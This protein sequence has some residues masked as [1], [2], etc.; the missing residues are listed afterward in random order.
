MQV[1]FILMGLAFAALLVDVVIRRP[2]VAAAIIMSDLVVRNA[3]VPLPSIPIGSVSIYDHDLVFALIGVAALARLLRK[4]SFTWAQRLLLLV[5]ALAGFSLLRGLMSFGVETAVNES[6]NWIFLLL[7]ALYFTTVVSGEV[8]DRV[9]KVIVWGAAALAA[10]AVMRWTVLALGG[11]TAFLGVRAGSGVRVLHAEMTLIIL[12]GFLILAVAW[13]RLSPRMRWLPAVLLAAVI[14]MQHR[15]VWVSL[16][17]GLAVLVYRDR[18]LARR[19]VVLLPAILAAAAIVVI[20]VFGR[21]VDEVAT[22]ATSTDTFEWRLLGWQELVLEEG[23]DG[24]TEVLFGKG[25]GSG[26]EREV[27][28]LVR[29][30]SPHSIYVESALRLGVFGTLALLAVILGPMIVLWRQPWVRPRQDR[31]GAP[32]LSNATLIVLLASNAAFGV[33]YFP[34]PT[35]G[36][37]LGVAASLVSHRISADSS[38]ARLASVQPSGRAA[39]EVFAHSGR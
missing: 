15:T 8:L 11:P 31:Y 13:R 30:E 28:N 23:P 1:L 12:Q 4:R 9:F 39:G 38:R 5:A 32:L 24:P 27:A 6:R 34:S 10:I 20:S 18:E 25:F 36:V 35:A 3:D 21:P 2:V 33:T 17:V 19:A 26:W 14:L 16:L 22:S 7:A 37:I 29:E